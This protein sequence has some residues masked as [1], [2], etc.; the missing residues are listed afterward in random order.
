[1]TFKGFNWQQN[2]K[3]MRKIWKPSVG[4]LRNCLN[5]LIYEK[6][7]MKAK[8]KFSNFQVFLFIYK[9]VYYKFIFKIK[10]FKFVYYLFANLP[11]N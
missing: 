3:N 9:F 8:N 6:T 4:V 2:L 10:L 1:M 7:G 11:Y 5:L